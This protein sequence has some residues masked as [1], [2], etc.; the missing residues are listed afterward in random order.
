MPLTPAQETICKDESR[1]RVAVTGRRF[2]KTHCAIREL[3][4]HAAAKD[5]AEVHYVSPSYRMSKSIVWDK[6]KEKLKEIAV[7]NSRVILP[8]LFFYRL[9]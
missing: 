6:L 9:F 3:A 7:Y 2:G 1:F 8:C 4:R 5:K